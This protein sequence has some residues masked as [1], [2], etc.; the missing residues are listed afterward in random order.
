[1]TLL[2]VSAGPGLERAP[3][4]LRADEPDLPPGAAGRHRR[5]RRG[6]HQHHTT[7]CAGATAWGRDP[8]QPPGAV[9]PL[10]PAPS[11]SPPA[12]RERARE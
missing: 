3:E 6:E 8:K 7:T 10:P 2:E 5:W 1:M 4:G 11:P 9:S 12:F